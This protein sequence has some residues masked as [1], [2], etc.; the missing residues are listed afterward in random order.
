MILYRYIIRQHILP[1]LYS[2]S[3]IIFIFIMQLAVDLLDRILSKG[4]DF[5]T[6]LEIFLAN[7]AW[8]FALAVPM[9]V[10]TACLMAFGQMSADN[11]ILAIKASGLNLYNLLTPV[12][13]AALVMTLLLIEFNNR[14]LPDANHRTSSLM[15]DISRK[16]P[17]ALIEPK[18]LIRDF[19]NYAIHVNDVLGRTGKVWGV[20]I[21]QDIPG[22]DPVTT[23]ADSGE[24][25][26]TRDEK[27]IQVTLYNGETHRI[28][29]ENAQEYFVGRFDRQVI[30]IEN[31]DSGLKRTERDF[32][33]DREKSAGDMLSEVAVFK[34]QRRQYLREHEEALT[35]LQAHAVTLDSMTSAQQ[36]VKPLDSIT[37]YQQWLA[38]LK[39]P[40]NDA[41]RTLTA[42][43]H[44][45]ERTI[46]RVRQQDLKIS[47]YMVEVHKKYSIPFTCI[48]FVLIGAPL[49]I[50]A[51]R[52]GLGVGASYSV[53][54]FV[55]FWAFLIG[56]ES[57]A[58]RLLVSPAVAM[59]SGNALIAA[60]GLFLIIRMVRE[61]VFISYLPL[62]RAWY[63]VLH[64]G[65]IVCLSN[66]WERLTRAVFGFPVWAAN[67]SAGILAA[68]IVR[69]FIK[70]LAGVIA[71][72]VVVFVVIDYVSNLRHFEAAHLCDV[73][74]YYWYYL[75]WFVTLIAPIGILLASMF[76]M[77]KL[78]KHSELIAMKAAGVSI[79]RITIPLLLLGIVLAV[80]NFYFTERVL[81]EANALRRELFEDIKAGRKHQ[82][83]QAVS[84]QP[85][86]HRNFYYFGSPDVVY[87]FQEFR[88]HPQRSRNVWRETFNK[89]TVVERVQADKLLYEDGRW[90]FVKGH[91][92]TFSGDTT[93]MAVFDTL[94][95]QVLSTTPEE[96]AANIKSVEEMSY[97]ELRDAI[98][99]AAKRGEKVHKYSADLHFKIALPF[100]NFIVI[101]LGI[102]VTARAGRKGGAVLFG[103]GLLIVF[104]YWILARFGLALGQD[105][106]VPPMLA[107]WGGNIIFFFL[108]VILY[109]KAAR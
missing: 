99:K 108:G 84:G 50:M 9:A 97:W 3:I 67:K 79:R 36:P 21:F 109:R 23:A 74:L 47:Q 12:F 88:T 42:A 101:L 31:I 27:Y 43:Q 98:E 95:D 64:L 61:T 86:F 25:H 89:N 40:A 102:S 100:M 78:A 55:V 19:N 35:L 77:G 65:W 15:A 94:A 56:G 93:T 33:G 18:V 10:L 30:F 75:A 4:L 1:F 60:C 87:C 73:L 14:V 91:V 69:L 2:L 22:E 41:V 83:R 34:D 37:T 7:L 90:F 54:F 85:L 13:L 51:K 59:W 16:K 26:V 96:M 57:M 105:G 106:R 48:V 58:D 66:G 71:A 39:G 82:S 104:S 62:Q 103:I 63:R 107:A 80:V 20:K 68:Y 52:G 46:R 76:A 24:L 17:A 49:G 11:E 53:F 70:Y 32:R 29:K 81:P 38:S 6:I 8:M 92:R 5:S 44:R 72:L 45:L 28:D